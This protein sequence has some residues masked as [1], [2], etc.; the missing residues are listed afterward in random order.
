MILSHSSEPRSR[1]D[2]VRCIVSNLTDDDTNE[3]LD[4][5]IKGYPLLRDEGCHSD[6]ED[7]DWEKWIPDPVDADPCKYRCTRLGFLASGIQY[8]VKLQS[9]ELGKLKDSI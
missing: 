9:F 5:L 4:E 2:T 8:T 1:D 7:E 6:D 3:L